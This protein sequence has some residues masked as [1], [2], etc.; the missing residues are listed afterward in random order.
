MATRPHNRP[1]AERLRADHR[2][3]RFDPSLRSEKIEKLSHA[4]AISR[5]LKSDLKAIANGRK[6][7]NS[8]TPEQGLIGSLIPWVLV[9]GFMGLR[10]GISAQSSHPHLL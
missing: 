7:K 1:L 2:H 10:M 5:S 8:S 9:E 6:Q 4:R 3:F